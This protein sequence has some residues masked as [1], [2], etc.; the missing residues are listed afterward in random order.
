LESFVE[1]P[2]ISEPLQQTVG[3]PA[4]GIQ[5][6][7]EQ[8]FNADELIPFRVVIPSRCFKRVE[9]IRK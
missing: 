7:V 4:E 2:K 8:Y 3:V 5:I 1:T 6:E 9:Q